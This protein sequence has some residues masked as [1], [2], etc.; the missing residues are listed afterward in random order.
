MAKKFYAVKKGLTPGIYETW[1]ECKRNVDGYS[2]AIYKSFKTYNEAASYLGCDEAAPL[3]LSSEDKDP[4][5]Q[6]EGAIA[7]VDGSYING[8][9]S[10]GAVIIP[11]K[12]NTDE[13]IKLS[14]KGTDKEMAE[15]RNVAGEIEGSKAAMRYATENGISRINIFH[16]YQGISSW[17]VGEWKTNKPGTFAYKKYYDEMRLMCDIRFYKVKGHSGDF[18]NDMADALAKE[19]LGI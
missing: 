2:G 12:N 18:Y 5:E 9:Y 11:D 19:A 1:D 4:W 6:I 3:G 13:I 10:Y 16:D 7:Y 8:E 17:C 15:M 14:G